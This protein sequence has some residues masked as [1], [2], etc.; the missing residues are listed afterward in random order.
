MASDGI[1]KITI[2]ADG[3]KAINSAKDLESVFGQLGKNG[4]TDNL[5]TFGLGKS[6]NNGYYQCARACEIGRHGIQ[7][8]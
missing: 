2:E 7:C 5:S 1:V 8:C 3:N 6:Q 4:Y